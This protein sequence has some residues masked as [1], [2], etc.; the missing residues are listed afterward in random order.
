MYIVKLSN[1][2]YT[3]YCIKTSTTT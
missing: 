2:I 3:Y 1:Q